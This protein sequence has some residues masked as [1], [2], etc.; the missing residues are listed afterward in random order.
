[1]TETPEPSPLLV[2]FAREWLEL[3]AAAQPAPLAELLAR[4][5]LAR[6]LLTEA[7]LDCELSAPTPADAGSDHAIDPPAAPGAVRRIGHYELLREVGRGGQAVVYEAR[8]ALLGRRV[9]LKVLQRGVFAVDLAADRL[10]AEAA[11]TSRL[12]H[13]GICPVY[14]VGED[15]D[16]LFLA[17]RFVDGHTLAHCI[18]TER[19]RATGGKPFELQLAATA[20]PT[21]SSTKTP[22]RVAA[23]LQWFEQVAA[24]LESAHRAGVCHR[25]IKPGNL[26]VQHDGAPVLLDFG[27]AGDRQRDGVSLTRSGDVFGT[28]AYMAPE[29]CRDARLA[30]TRTDVFALGATLFEALTG[31]RAFQ[32]ETPEATVRLI[33]A[34]RV[35]NPCRLVRS[36]PREI[37]IVL[38]KALDP[39]PSRRYQSALEFAQDLQRIRELRPVRAVPPGVPLRLRRFVQRNPVLT[40]FATV[41]LIAF[42]V[43]LTSLQDAR[44]AKDDF[45]RL[46]DAVRHEDL[47]RAFDNEVFP[48]SRNQVQAAAW[49]TAAD[50][51]AARL[52]EHRRRL[53]ELRLQ[54]EP[55]SPA[56]LASSQHTHPLFAELERLQT[57]ERSLVD[58][59]GTAAALATAT[60]NAEATRARIAA[61][62]A[63]ML[64][65]RPRRFAIASMQVVHDA[66]ARLVTDLTKFAGSDGPLEYVRNDLMR[67]R[68]DA[69]DVAAWR[70][71]T[72]EIRALPPYRGLELPVQ[73]GLQPLR[74]DP[75]S[76]LWEFL[77]TASGKPPTIDAN[78]SYLVSAD[79]GI[80]LVLLPG[81]PCQLGCSDEPRSPRFDEQATGR[82]IELFHSEV[83]LEPFFIGKYEVT[84][85]QWS[86]LH[87][88]EN[89]SAYRPGANKYGVEITLVHPVENID[90][91][92]AGRTLRMIGL[93]LPT[94]AQWEYAARAGTD[95]PFYTGDRT[96][97]AGKTNLYDLDAK[98]A[99]FSS[100]HAPRPWHDGFVLH[101][102]VGS[103]PPNGFGLCD[104]IG[105]VSEF[106]LDDYTHPDLFLR[107]AGDALLLATPEGHHAKRGAC[108]GIDE[109][110]GR[111]G[112]RSYAISRDGYWGV[113]AARS[114]DR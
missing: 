43:V 94:E 42:I 12:D 104:M 63:T 16:L 49:L 9:A 61:I 90:W 28:P 114:I 10:R 100:I 81:G 70:A 45:G 76:N 78:G 53:A 22:R 75:K 79:T 69:A 48:V 103:F 85:A 26:M 2:A 105:N 15:G 38:G 47:M 14:E 111:S 67:A 83:D 73:G 57:I 1:M 92:E 71:A 66:L 34:G 86:R 82:S 44:S 59:L 29:Q 113:R 89:P 41:V 11:T 24:A 54:S 109:L 30:D 112:A 46:A 35:P 87:H 27:L 68:N 50:D 95:T 106:C 56:E 18:A 72:A 64:E 107:R 31:Q 40:A 39:D 91:S 37:G 13:P 96:S 8:D 84:Q 101:S 25:D 60:A 33:F 58:R 97:L 65:D 55:A 17:M 3:T 52:P 5:P 80:V 23:V 99:G 77:V 88:G 36:L 62:E 20:A 6:E 4:H 19:D 21:E 7:L 93:G 108:F 51:L 32:A 98:Q 102:P 110:L 74:R